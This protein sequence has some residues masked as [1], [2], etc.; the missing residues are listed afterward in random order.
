MDPVLHSKIDELLRTSLFPFSDYKKIFHP[1]QWLD[2]LNS[3][4][5]DG[6]NKE[7]ESK[8]AKVAEPRKVAEFWKVANDELANP[9]MCRVFIDMLHR[10][11][12]AAIK[13]SRQ[14]VPFMDLVE[15][16]GLSLTGVDGTVT[17]GHCRLLVQ[18]INILATSK[19]FLI[20]QY[21]TRSAKIIVSG[22]KAVSASS[23]LTTDFLEGILNAVLELDPGLI[24]MVMAELWP[25]WV[26]GELLEIMAKVGTYLGR[27]SGSTQCFF[28]TSFF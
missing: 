6:D 20:G 23:E 18:F 1:K 7:P 14:S 22:I 28:L 21:N 9:D 2:E 16:C 25:Y 19:A 24:S 13:R 5:I 11:Y 4:E 26:R 8:R 27:K 12:A 3:D 17:A 10:A 15:V